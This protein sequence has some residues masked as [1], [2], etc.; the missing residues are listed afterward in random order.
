MQPPTDVATQNPTHQDERVRVDLGER[1]YDILIGNRLLDSVGTLLTEVVPGAKLLLLSDRAVET[2]WAKI[3][4]KSLAETDFDVKLEPVPNGESSKSV[5]MIAHLWDR[6]AEE[7]FSRD[8]AVV[9]LGGGVIGDLGGFLAAS[10]LRGIPYIQVPTTLLAMV[11]SS[12]GGKTGINLSRGKNL[13]GSFWQ[14]RMVIADLDCLGTLPEEER[15]SGLAEVIKYGVIRD[16]E[17]FAFLEENIANL[18]HG[19]EAD[20]LRHVIQRSIEI[21]AEVVT[22]DEREG[23]LRRILNFGHTLGH[24]I[25]AEADYGGLR[26]GECVAIGMIAASM[27]TLRRKT[28]GWSEKEHG[29]LHN[30]IERAGLPSRIPDGMDAEALVDRTRVDKKVRKGQV[31]YILPTRIGNVEAVRDVT[32]QDALAVLRDLGAR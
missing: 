7:N 26:H 11:D 13:V 25:E 27:I 15:T 18:F 8:S 24:A 22:S 1:S 29:R 5:E 19:A 32:E 2:P 9:A 10:F 31:R 6:L 30:L 14:P 17:F 4:K 20:K 12:V 23:G 21:K 3:I 16:A 28:Q